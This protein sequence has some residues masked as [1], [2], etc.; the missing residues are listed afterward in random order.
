MA[1]TQ[2]HAMLFEDFPAERLAWPGNLPRLQQATGGL[3]QSSF[4]AVIAGVAEVA[5]ETARE[6]VAR[7]HDGLRA[8]ERVEWAKA[9]FEGWLILQAYEGMLRAMEIRQDSRLRAVQAKTAIAELAESLLQRICRVIGGGSFCRSSPFGNWLR[10]F[11]LSRFCG[12]PWGSR[13]TKSS[14]AD[15]KGASSAGDRTTARQAQA[16]PEQLAMSWV[17][18]A[19]SSG[20][21]R[22]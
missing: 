11:E 22:A 2:S 16:R 9:E 21:T 10:T 7:R 12:L 3:T 8:C 1:A 19:R 4:T 20:S 17:A 13:T 14:P 6:H 5:L 15:R 18:T